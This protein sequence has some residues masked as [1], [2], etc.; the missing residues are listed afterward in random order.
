MTN[1][2]TITVKNS[3]MTTATF[4]REPLVTDYEIYPPLIIHGAP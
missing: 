2:L 1:P 4:S 3:R